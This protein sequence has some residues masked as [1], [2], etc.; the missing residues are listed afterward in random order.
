MLK[1]LNCFTL[2]FILM[3][4]LLS[5]INVNASSNKVKNYYVDVNKSLS[6]SIKGIKR[7]PKIS[8]NSIKS[9]RVS[10]NKLTLKASKNIGVS[11]FKV[12]NTKYNIVVINSKLDKYIIDDKYT[13]VGEDDGVFWVIRGDKFHS[14]VTV[15]N[16]N[17]YV[18][19]VTHIRSDYK[20]K[21]TLFE[22]RENSIKTLGTNEEFTFF[23]YSCMPYHKDKIRV[24]KSKETNLTS[25]RNAA[26]VRIEKCTD[27]F[28][29]FELKNNT[30]K[31][32]SIS[33]LYARVLKDSGS[34][35]FTTQTHEYFLSPNEVITILDKYGAQKSERGVIIDYRVVRSV[36]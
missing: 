23:A 17:P 19:D 27:D 33:F 2:V 11:S 20:D 32:V 4:M 24:E 15:L 9:A 8:G 5:P 29:H 30:D 36:D 3:V 1:R 6:I 18:V 14:Y 21:D 31:T 22:N 35:V 10:K 12:K 25:D 16:T 26:S 13:E 7:V 34:Y 28:T